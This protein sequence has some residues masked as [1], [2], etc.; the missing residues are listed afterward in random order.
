[1][2]KQIVGAKARFRSWA[3]PWADTDTSTQKEA[4]RL[5]R[6]GRYA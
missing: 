6:G 4:A 1:M 5:S 2:V 3:E